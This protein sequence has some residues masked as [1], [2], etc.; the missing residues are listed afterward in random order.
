ML[1]GTTSRTLPPS[2][3]HATAVRCGDGAPRRAAEDLVVVVG[4]DGRRAPAGASDGIGL[5]SQ[6]EDIPRRPL[7]R[8]PCNAGYCLVVRTRQRSGPG[9]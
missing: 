8:L 3:A 9:A 7:M 5:L 4:D 6:Q 1:T 2:N